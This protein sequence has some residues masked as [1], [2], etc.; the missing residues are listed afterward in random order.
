MIGKGVFIIVAGI[1][2][3]VGLFFT[4]MV[5]AMFQH[6]AG[7]GAEKLFGPLLGMAALGFFFISDVC[8]VAATRIRKRVDSQP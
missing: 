1:S 3:L 2:V 8:L 7:M 4:M 6:P 5:I